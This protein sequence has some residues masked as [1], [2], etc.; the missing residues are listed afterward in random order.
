MIT[1][2]GGSGTR[3]ISEVMK[4]L[5]I[6]CYHEHVFRS[7][8]FSGWAGIQG[9]SSAY[10]APCLEDHSDIIVFHQTR[11]PLKWIS[12]SNNYVVSQRILSFKGVPIV[13]TTIRGRYVLGFMDN[14][15]LFWVHWNEMVEASSSTHEYYRYKIEDIED[16][17]PV[18]LDILGI[19]KTSQEQIEAISGVNRHSSGCKHKTTLEDVKHDRRFIDKCEKYGYNL[20]ETHSEAK[21]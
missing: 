2:T 13:D 7:N 18:I 8:G 10:A 14:P 4:D 15:T 16:E 17:L 19:N 20:E 9:D 12:T 3:F 11:D 5:D 21:A 1:G 6:K